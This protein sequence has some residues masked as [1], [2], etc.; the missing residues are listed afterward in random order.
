M[1]MRQ[2]FT[3]AGVTTLDGGSRKGAHEEGDVFA[4]QLNKMFAQ[5]V[6]RCRVIQANDV[7]VTALRK[8]ND[9]SI[10]QHD[11]DTG[12]AESLGNGAIDFV[13]PGGELERRKENP[14]HS[15]LDELFAKFPRVFATAILIQSGM[16]RTAPQQR[17]FA[18]SRETRQLAT[19][20]FKNLSRA[21]TGYQQ[22]DLTRLAE[23][24]S[25][26]TEVGSGAGTAL[27]NPLR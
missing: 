16:S 13:H 7:E 18:F 15:P 11:R 9:V 2:R 8:G 23:D 27:N 21:Q 1:M 17:V 26:V 22:A 3:D 20:N 14:Y 10:Q 6:T 25:L 5:Q 4:A 24:D 12:V 19:N